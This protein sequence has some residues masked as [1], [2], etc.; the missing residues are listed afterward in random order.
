MYHGARQGVWAI[1]FVRWLFGVWNLAGNPSSD[2]YGFFSIKAYVL[3]VEFI[4]ANRYRL[5]GK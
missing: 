1:A 2:L 5:R 4:G 3:E